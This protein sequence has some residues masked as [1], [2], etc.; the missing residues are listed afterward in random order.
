[1]C[2]VFCLSDVIETIITSNKTLTLK[3]SNGMNTQEK[4]CCHTKPADEKAGKC[5][6][7]TK[8]CKHEVKDEACKRADKAEGTIDKV[9]EKAKEALH[10]TKEKLADYT[11]KAKDKLSEVKDKLKA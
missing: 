8:A 7:E 3:I 1:M 2:E 11:D 10:E 4:G 9:K 5:S 6:K